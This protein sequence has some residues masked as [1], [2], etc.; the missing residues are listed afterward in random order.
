MLTA[1]PLILP[2]QPI[3]PPPHA[4]TNWF[5]SKFIAKHLHALVLS[6]A[7]VFPRLLPYHAHFMW[8]VLERPAPIA[9][10]GFWSPQFAK[11]KAAADERRAVKGEAGSTRL[12]AVPAVEVAGQTG[13]SVAEAATGGQGLTVPRLAEVAGFTP[14]LTPE[15]SDGG[16]EDLVAPEAKPFPML[17]AP[18]Y[19]VDTSENIFNYD[20][21]L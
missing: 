18:T 9:T 12:G 1:S 7:R 6:I 2:T 14:P 15:P 3:T 16:K 11:L 21:G 8:T 5:F 4:L 19:K 10:A 17:V 13:R 20:C